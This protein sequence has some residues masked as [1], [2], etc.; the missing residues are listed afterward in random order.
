M[1]LFDFL[2][3]LF[4]RFHNNQLSEEARIA[5]REIIV[6]NSGPAFL[7]CSYVVSLLVWTRAM[8]VNGN[9]GHPMQL[10]A[11]PLILGGHGDRM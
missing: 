4:K 9:Q 8:M 1:F 3:F 10:G 2:C 6:G 11:L 5:Q 7:W